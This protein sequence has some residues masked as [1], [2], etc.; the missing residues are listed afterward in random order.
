MAII[1]FVLIGHVDNGKTTVAGRILVDTKTVDEREVEKAIEDAT[2]N[3]MRSWWL[4]YLLD[5][6][7]ERD[8]GKTYEHT[9][10]PIIHKEVKV[11]MIDVPG[12]R[13]YV[14]EMIA[15][16][17][18]AN[19]AVLICSAKKGEL[20]SGIKGQTYEHL[21]LARAMGI[22][23]LI[24]AINKMDH[25]SVKW[26]M[27]IFEDVK[28]T[29]NDLIKNLN[30]VQVHYVPISA[31]EGTNV[32]IS[33]INNNN[34]S[35][36]D[37]I[38]ETQINPNRNIQTYLK[39]TKIKIMCRFIGIDNVITLGYTCNLHT[40]DQTV[41]CVLTKI[42]GLGKKRFITNQDT[43][44]NSIQVELTLSEPTDI[45]TFVILRD[46]DKTIGVGKIIV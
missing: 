26:D 6:G 15:G 19:L 24:V 30:F 7:E 23:K 31:L 35:L 43:I 1:N 20:E 3:N 16:T 33:N 4:A 14:R 25:E 18:V 37:I 41:Q 32:V 42:Y 13:K 22:G 8:K 21:L 17:A 11:N 9:I 12:H 34:K 28:K 27:N 44:K 2:A 40:S 10:I 45:K 5:I 38:V 29:V 46:G 36:M 39:Q